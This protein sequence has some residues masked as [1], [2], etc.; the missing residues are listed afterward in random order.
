MRF[1]RIVVCF[2]FLGPHPQHMEVPRVGVEL[3]LYLP[4]YI[5]AHRILNPLS[6]ARDQT[7]IL[8]DTSRF[9]STAPQQELPRELQF[10]VQ[11]NIECLTI[12]Q[13]CFSSLVTHQWDGFA[14]VQVRFMAGHEQK[15]MSPMSLCQNAQM[16]YSTSPTWGHIPWLTS[17]ALWRAKVSTT[18]THCPGF[19]AG[20]HEPSYKAV[21]ICS[22][23]IY[24]LGG[25][26]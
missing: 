5:T 25:L 18:S 26:S 16:I 7:C 15:L 20:P 24:S 17:S 8:V 1:Q 3:E 9:I 13:I 4:A 2:F 14:T 6:E 12:S 10:K 21:S 11:Y 19:N 22:L 23:L